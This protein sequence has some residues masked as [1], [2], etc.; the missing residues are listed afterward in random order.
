MILQQP[1]FMPKKRIVWGEKGLG[2][3]TLP[4]E[5]KNCTSQEIRKEGFT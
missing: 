2:R 1:Y 3:Q 4:E 5:T